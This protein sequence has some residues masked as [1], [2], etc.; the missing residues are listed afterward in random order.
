MA[1]KHKPPV[2]AK[3]GTL[4]I[5][6]KS[7]R[8]RILAVVYGDDSLEERKIRDVDELR[9][10]D[11]RGMK[12]WVDIQ[13][14]GDEATLR[15]LGDLF[16]IH[17]LALEDIVHIPI[18]PKSEPY[19]Q[20][21]LI[22]SRMLRHTDDEVVN[23]EQV[24]IVVGRDYVLT[25]QEDY[26]DVLDP[27]RHRLNVPGSKMRKEGPDYLAYAI[28][29][30]IIDAYYPVI[31]ALGDRIEELEERVLE[32][33]S[34]ETLRDLTEIKGTLLG[35]RRAVT[36]QREA[37]NALIRDECDLV[38]DNVRLFLRDTYDHIVQT[39]EAV[40]TAREL[41]SGLMNTYLS[42]VSNRMN[43]VMKVLT[44]VASI[45]IP[46][47]FLAGIYGMNFEHM[48]ELHLRWG[49]PILI[50]VMAIIGVG[51]LFY[52]KRKGWL[53]RSDR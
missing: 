35:L 36:P 48:P 51:M 10:F 21:L 22:I 31:E 15:A 13:G 44:I 32:E 16:S 42:V 29:D 43:E 33:A 2:G 53:G 25:F 14:L 7:P 27:V 52:F 20:N 39:S 6:P 24:G 34:P 38:G 9:G 11:R 5:N 46:V 47:T 49:Y 40:E 1:A 4:A 17:P 50:S 23:T 19:E 26:D 45:F 3:P 18:R 8:P 41:V 12:L 30:T 28:L 37:V